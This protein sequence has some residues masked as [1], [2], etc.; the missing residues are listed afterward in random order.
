MV[1]LVCSSQ[2][3]KK[4][5]KLMSLNLQTHGSVTEKSEQALVFS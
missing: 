3:V 1:I 4:E 2:F 5:D